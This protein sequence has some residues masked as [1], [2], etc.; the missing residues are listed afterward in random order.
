MD[1]NVII[2]KGNEVYQ[3]IK[4][5]SNSSV[6]GAKIKEMLNGVPNM[7]KD[8]GLESASQKVQTIVDKIDPVACIEDFEAL[9]NVTGTLIEKIKNKDI[10]GAISAIVE[11]SEDVS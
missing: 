4:N 8:C 3:D 1:A 10:S 5:K 11:F 9:K 6:V 2:A 7:L